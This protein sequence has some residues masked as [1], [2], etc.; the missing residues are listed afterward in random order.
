MC[1]TSRIFKAIHD[2]VMNTITL[3]SFVYISGDTSSIAYYYS[4]DDSNPRFYFQNVTFFKTSEEINVNNVLYAIIDIHQDKNIVKIAIPEAHVCKLEK[5]YNEAVC[6]KTLSCFEV[7]SEEQIDQTIQKLK[8]Y[9][10]SFN[11]LSSV[12]LKDKLRKLS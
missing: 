9:N 8:E 7:I 12:A 10:E 3:Y 1:L 6:T 4:M 2:S 5:Q 11:P